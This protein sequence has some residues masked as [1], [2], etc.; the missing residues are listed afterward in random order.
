[1]CPAGRSGDLKPLQIERLL[2][3]IIQA[4][5]IGY[6]PATGISEE[7]NAEAILRHEIGWLHRR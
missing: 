4:A 5:F 3:Q 1:M 6:D 7:S 2:D